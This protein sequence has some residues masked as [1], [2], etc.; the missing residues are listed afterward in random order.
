[1]RTI[2]SW[3]LVAALVLPGSA[4][5]Q[6]EIYSKHFLYGYPTGTP[7][8]NDLIIRDLYALSNNDSTKFADWV[9]YRLTAAEVIGTLD[10]QRTW[11]A[12]PWLAP[13]ETLEPLPDDY[14]GAF[15]TQQ[16]Q[17]GH[18]APLAS[19]K[20]SADASQVDYYSNIV[21]Q[22]V[23]LN[24]GPWQRLEQAERDIV[25]AGNVLW[26]MTGPLYDGPAAAPLP[27]ADEPH[28][29]P[30]GFWKILAKADGG[31]SVAAFV[32]EQSTPRNDPVVNHLTTVATIESR[33]GLDFF[34]LLPD[35]TETKIQ[36]R[37]LTPQEWSAFA[38]ASTCDRAKVQP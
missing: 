32:F 16:Y 23:D 36:A 35:T 9:A 26:V 24:E 18:L 27:D 38:P 15:H 5:G 28:V 11:R 8:T 21:P 4:W 19:F 22:K 30:T 12:D 20:G 13:N 29:V 37:L 7:A 6:S 2:L 33:T 25:C 31:L 14:E 10:L 3:T 17:R 34:R 1:M